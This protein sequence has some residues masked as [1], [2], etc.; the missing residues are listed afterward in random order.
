MRPPFASL[1]KQWIGLCVT[2]S[3]TTFR[4]LSFFVAVTTVTPQLM[5]P[6]VAELS[7]P[8]RRAMMIS[9]NFAG[10][11]MG[12]LFARVISGI[13]TQFTSWRT[14]Y[15]VALGIQYTLFIVLFFALPDYPRVNP[16]SPSS[17]AAASSSADAK[18]TSAA[19]SAGNALATYVRILAS[20]VRIAARQPILVQVSL[21]CFFISAAYVGFWTTLTFL[22]AS[23]PFN[24]NTI[25]I[26]LFSLIGMPPF[27][28]SPHL[29]HFLTKHFHSVYATLSGLLVALV[30]VLIGTFVGTY[31]LAGPV[32]MGFLV[33]LGLIL[34]Q[35]SCRM[36]LVAVEP[37]ARNRVNT[38]YMV[39]GFFG[40]LAGTSICNRLYAMGGWYYS[41]Y[42]EISFVVVAIGFAIVRGPHETRWFGYRGGWRMASSIATAG[43]GGEAAT[44]EADAVAVPGSSEG[45]SAG[46]E[47]RVQGQRTASPSQLENGGLKDKMG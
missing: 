47:K 12:L 25:D 15:L 33:D 34:C 43:D 40:M 37:Q 36:Q 5:L 35:T 22:L 1:T 28:I 45:S 7:P 23:P 46:D 27:F 8:K 21:V 31:S 32:I 2:K 3:F 4:I 41:G 26:G 18:G 39:T 17:A 11:F 19:S 29:I 24:L 16:A 30:G 10:L 20:M 42:A 6:L 13:A 9:I 44:I 14:I 38:I